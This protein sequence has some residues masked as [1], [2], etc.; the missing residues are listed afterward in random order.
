MTPLECGHSPAELLMGITLWTNVP[1]YYKQLQCKVS[2][3]STLQEK[4]QKIKGRQKH[5]FDS[6]HST[7]SFKPLNLGDDVWLPKEMTTATVQSSAR[8]RS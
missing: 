2:N 8:S 1:T 4:E 7:Q 6:R 3:L 5:N